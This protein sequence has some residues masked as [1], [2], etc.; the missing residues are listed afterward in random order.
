VQQIYSDLLHDF[1]D[2]EAA[3][4][5]RGGRTGFA[6]IGGKF[7]NPLDPGVVIENIASGQDLPSPNVALA[8]VSLASP[9]STSGPVDLS[10]QPPW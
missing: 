8:G 3:V 10:F 6:A 5:V 1:G 9:L 7:I 2:V 4:R